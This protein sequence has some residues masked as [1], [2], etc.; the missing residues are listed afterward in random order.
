VP[1]WQRVAEYDE[2]NP[3]KS[4][5]QAGAAL[6]LDNSTVHRA[7]QKSGVDGATPDDRPTIDKPPK[8]L[9]EAW[10]LAGV[11]SAFEPKDRYG[12]WGRTGKLSSIESV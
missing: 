10:M 1:A 2:A 12:A 11:A 5:R 4:T 6:G 3:G 9:L 8:C 7:R